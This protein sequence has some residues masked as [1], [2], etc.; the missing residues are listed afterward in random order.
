MNSGLF[1]SSAQQSQ[2][3]KK[4]HSQACLI[5][6]YSITN[7]SQQQLRLHRFWAFPAVKQMTSLCLKTRRLASLIFWKK[8]CEYP[9]LFP[10]L[11]PKISVSEP[12]IGYQVS[13][14]RIHLEH[15]LNSNI[16]KR[17]NSYSIILRGTFFSFF[18]P[19]LGAF[20]HFSNLFKKYAG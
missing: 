4:P 6:N 15:L 16:K 14:E 20:R 7:R 13:K 12:W 11:S 3:S 19:P 9:L 8:L 17:R 10:F 5:Q 18:W 1:F 2:L